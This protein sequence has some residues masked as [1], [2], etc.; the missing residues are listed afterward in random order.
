MKSA[1]KHMDGLSLHYY[2]V[3]DW[4]DKGSATEF[5]DEVYYS[6]LG[7]ALEIEP[8]IRRHK[9]IM[10]SYDPDGKVDLIVDEWGT[11]FDEEPGTISGH[12]YQ[13]NTMRDAIVAALTL[14]VF[15]RHTDR[16]K[17]TNIAQI[18]NVLQ[19]MILTNEKEMVLTPTYH[20]FHMYR[21]HQGSKYLPTECDCGERKLDDE[22]TV[23]DVS[24]TASRAGD[25]AIHISIVN[26]DLTT[27]RTLQIQTERLTP[28]KV[29]GVILTTDNIS[30]YNDF[31]HKTKVGN[32]PFNDF[33]VK[34]NSVKVELPAKSIVT[35]TLR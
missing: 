23:P 8:V 27:S 6:T 29:T 3:A 4:D 22:R 14:N 24:V 26:P 5:S 28:K 16:V 12:L 30:D 35:L 17:M 2:T 19:S 10:D 34:N 7:K 31:S 25:G 1:G 9:A 32:R 11:W 18:V 20:V 15:H 33:L 21:V 13:Q